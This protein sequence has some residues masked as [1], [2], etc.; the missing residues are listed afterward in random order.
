M[1]S[2]S[3]SLVSAASVRPKVNTSHTTKTIKPDFAFY[4]GK[5]IT[6]IVGGSAGGTTDLEYLA[7]VNQLEKI[8]GA[9]I[10]AEIVGGSTASQK[11]ISE[12]RIQTV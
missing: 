10:N 1:T 9:T 2:L 3:G 12:E 7:V 11:G 5:T 8:L 6:F 4:K